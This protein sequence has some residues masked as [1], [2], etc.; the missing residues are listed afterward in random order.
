MSGDGV[1]LSA[2]E[3][4]R[5]EQI[6]A[7]TGIS[8]ALTY[9][10]T[11]DEV[12][13]LVVERAAEVMD[14]DRA[15]LMLSDEEGLLRVRAAHGIDAG[16]VEK[17]REPLNES[18]VK[19][20]TGVLDFEP[21]ASFL[22][23]PLVVQG[24]VTGLLAAVRP[25]DRPARDSDEWVL[26][27]LADQAAVALEYARLDE[28]VRAERTE[29]V[30][31]VEKV[32]EDR[33]RIHATLSHELR[34]PLTA[35]LS[36]S[37]LLLEELFGPLTDRQ[38]ESLARIRM[39]GHHLLAI[40]ENVLDMARLSAGVIKLSAADVLVSEIVAEAVQMIQPSAVEKEQELA[41]LPVPGLTTRADPN[42]LRQALVNVLVNA[43]RY[44]PPGGAI[45]VRVA[46]SDRAGTAFAA[47][48]VADT[49][50]GIAA[51]DLAAIFEPY[52]RGPQ[53]RTDQGLGLGLSISRELIRQ[54]GGDIEV[55]SAPGAGTTFTLYV[56]LAPDAPPA[57]SP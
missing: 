8:R 44:T 31:S 25:A 15:V 9:A 12:L 48:S 36:Y 28:A 16:R 18:L 50:P 35:I 49:G 55:E 6:R 20:L 52:H 14:A 43:V 33:D 57:S 40:I 23:V 27:A 21:G 45:Q 53:V 26:S 2:A 17:F 11:I 56:P 13:R 47:L 4:E 46:A 29:R 24:A 39:S 1:G 34:S 41:V 5:Y 32:V 42:R 51:D 38:R 10:R 19:R 30:R 37:S 7:L 3:R 54:M 22:S